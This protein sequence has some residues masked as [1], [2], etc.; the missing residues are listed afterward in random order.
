MWLTQILTN[1]ILIGGFLY[2][3]QKLMQYFFHYSELQ[4][5]CTADLR[6]YSRQWLA[7]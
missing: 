3:H 6:T 5:I 2:N 1:E 4:M 7:D